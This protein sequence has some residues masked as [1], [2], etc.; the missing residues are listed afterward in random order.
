[1][2]SGANIEIHHKRVPV[3]YSIY[4]LL[5]TYG[6]QVA[7]YFLVDNEGWEKV[8]ALVPFMANAFYNAKLLALAEAHG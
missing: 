6:P 2:A 3:L 5:F 1:V 8:H 4:Q 7:P